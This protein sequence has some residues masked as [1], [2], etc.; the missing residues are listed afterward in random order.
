MTA[1]GQDKPPRRQEMVPRKEKVKKRRKKEVRD[2][3]K[4]KTR[5]GVTSLGK[6]K[7]I[8]LNG[9]NDNKNFIKVLKV[10]KNF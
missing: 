5:G 2:I 4:E 9:S 1:R 6:E 8:E 3:N 7:K 10:N